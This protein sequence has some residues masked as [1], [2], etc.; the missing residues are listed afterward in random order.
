MI[1]HICISEKFIPPF[2]ALTEKYYVKRHHFAFITRESYNYNL[3]SSS[4]HKFY[5]KDDDFVALT[6]LLKQCEK[7][8][9]HGIWRD[10]V[11]DI[12]VAHP[13]LLAKTYW[14]MWG[15][16][17]YYP[18][19][20]L[21]NHKKVIANVPYIVT[22]IQEDVDWVKE[23]YGAKGQFIFGLIYAKQHN[24]TPRPYTTLNSCPRVLLGNS[25]DK[26]NLHLEALAN[27]QKF[28]SSLD[29]YCPLSYSGQ[30]EYV[31][32]VTSAGKKA[33][34]DLFTPMTAYMALESYLDFLASVD[35]AFFNQNRQQGLNNLMVFFDI[36]KK[37]F[38]NNTTT[39]WKGLNRLGFIV[40][41][42]EAFNT[43]PLTTEQVEHN[44]KL[45]Q[46]YFSLT[47]I[48]DSLDVIFEEN[49]SELRP[50]M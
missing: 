18:E 13:D 36:G 7:I 20:Y 50:P 48:L 14:F 26:S 3:Q 12:L 35:I 44:Q 40:F 21:E 30:P 46:Q 37:V 38:L 45:A 11:N 34:G 25:A 29:I 22:G 43:N 39:M 27:L 41:S 24:V 47:S 42:T 2:I 8:V 15:G 16:D 10:K 1:V 5:Y 49:S 32:S 31:D 17:F 4:D 6:V 33:F 28:G 19:R 23:V 9:L